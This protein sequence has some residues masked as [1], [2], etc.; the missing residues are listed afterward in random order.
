MQER[1]V[2]GV[3]ADASHRFGGNESVGKPLFRLHEVVAYLVEKER[4]ASYLFEGV[5]DVLFE[6]VII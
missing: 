2:V 3:R 6:G 1:C 4:L 5:G